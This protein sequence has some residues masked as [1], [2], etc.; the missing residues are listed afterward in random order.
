MS[1]TRLTGGLEPDVIAEAHLDAPSILTGIQRFGAERD[2]RMA[3][4][5]NMLAALE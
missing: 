2:R 5:R 3:R 4:Q 1:T